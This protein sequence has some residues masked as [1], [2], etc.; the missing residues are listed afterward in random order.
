MPT[1][2]QS[3]IVTLVSLLLLSLAIH[4]EPTPY[5]YEDRALWFSL[6]QQELELDGSS[7]QFYSPDFSAPSHKLYLFIGEVTEPNNGDALAISG[8][9]E[10]TGA[11]VW[12]L[13][14][15]DA[16]FMDRTRIALRG[17]DGAFMVS[18]M[19]GLA[20]RFD[21][22]VIITMDVASV[23]VLRGLRSWQT[24][25]D[26]AQREKLAQVLLLY[27]SLYVNTPVAGEDRELFP[28][29]ENTALPIT[30]MQPALGAQSETISESVVALRRGG[31]LVHLKPLPNTLDGIF[32]YQDI[33]ERAAS[34]PRQLLEAEETMSR[35][36]NKLKYPIHSMPELE[37][38]APKT[39]IVAGLKTIKQP[40]PMPAIEL[41]TSDGR[42]INIGQ[43]HQGKAML[44]NFWATW[45]PHCVEE[46]PSMNRAMKLLEGQPFEM[47]SISFKDSDEVMADFLSKI[48][49]HFPV[50]MDYDG[51]VSKRWKVFA[52]PSSFLVDRRGMVRYSINS[53][54]IWDEPSLVEVMLELARAPH[55]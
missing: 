37:W 14:T 6:Q 38:Q 30:I 55:Q 47:V 48:D 49:V 32:K 34:F 20:E 45:C 46:I 1:P 43:A 22:I 28:I 11:S 13:D 51:Q 52:F 36:R 25:A 15:P 31:S 18:L 4:A 24:Q 3:S 10:L 16:L 54:A 33:R 29:T 27:P 44:I 7:F 39:R 12:Y 26:K 17:H 50:L 41:T 19:K 42:L 40:Y 35:R 21:E 23:P 5:E 2:F 8:L 53:G 9:A